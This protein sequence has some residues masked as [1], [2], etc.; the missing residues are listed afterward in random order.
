MIDPDRVPK[1]PRRP[2]PKTWRSA[3][4]KLWR[5]RG[6]AR[7]G[8]IVT[9]GRYET[10]PEAQFDLQRLTLGGDYRNLEIQAL[11]PPATPLS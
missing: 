2:P 1:L 10:E 4:P 11:A 7:D 3:A 6:K 8:L 5:I 9:L